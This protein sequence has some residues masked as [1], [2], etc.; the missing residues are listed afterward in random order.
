[1]DYLRTAGSMLSTFIKK[2]KAV[3]ERIVTR[4]VTYTRPEPTSNYEI[5]V[6]E[7]PVG[8]PQIIIF[9]AVN[10]EYTT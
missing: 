6:R 4:N 10:I 2:L 8:D 7:K 5:E 1:M 9:G 3:R